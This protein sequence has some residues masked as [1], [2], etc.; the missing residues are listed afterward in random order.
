MKKNRLTFIAVTLLF[1]ADTTARAQFI[2]NNA[3]VLGNTATDR[4]T[5]IDADASGNFYCAGDFHYYID[6]DPG[7]GAVYLSSVGGVDAYAAKYN[8]AGAL[9]WAFSIGGSGDDYIYSIR[10][11]NSGN[12]FIAGMFTDVV[13]FDPGSG[14]AD[15]TSYGGYDMFIAK[16]NS[17]GNYLW[18]YNYGETDDEKILELAYDAGTNSIV[19]TGSFTSSAINVDPVGTNVLM[20]ASDPGFGWGDAFVASYNATDGSLNWAF[21]IGGLKGDDGFGVITDDSGNIYAT[22]SFSDA[23][24][25]FDPG[26]GSALLTSAG[27]IDAYIAKYSSA[28][29]FQWVKGV[30]GPGGDIGY[31]LAADHNGDVLAGGYFNSDSVDFDPGPNTHYIHTNGVQDLFVLKLSSSG[32]YQWSF[33][34][35]DVNSEVTQDMAVDSVGNIFITGDFGNT[36]DFDPGPGT[37]NL[38]G[39]T[40]SD[41]YLAEYTPAGQFVDALS[42]TGN[43]YEFGIGVCVLPG[44]KVGLTGFFSSA[45]IDCDPGSGT[46]F[47]VNQTGITWSEAF[48][49]VYS[50]APTGIGELLNRQLSLSLSP[51]PVQSELVVKCKMNM[52]ELKVIDVTGKEIYT[53]NPSAKVVRLKVSDFSPG[54]Y[55]VQAKSGNATGMQKLVVR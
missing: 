21:P 53:S 6:A 31:A 20:N 29:V 12:V 24:V 39:S 43:G 25:D 30:G 28:G 50:Y 54:V 17:S 3:F 37:F 5:S 11:D 49:S 40:E 48:V 1:F 23:D 35:G 52:D 26:S 45:S 14:T 32:Q 51:N 2:Y 4:G 10:S 18:A 16:Y 41:L 33:G 55:F 44:S 9:Q 15:L 22:G 8:S 34:I 19:V 46:A 38:T 7:S 47:L 13:D 36:V 27:S 42:Y